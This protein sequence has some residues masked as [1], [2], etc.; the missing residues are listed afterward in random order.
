M[1]LRTTAPPWQDQ[2]LA[3][4]VAVAI[5]TGANN[6][7]GPGGSV[8]GVDSYHGGPAFHSG[9]W[10]GGDGGG[11]GGAGD[12][13]YGGIVNTYMTPGKLIDTVT[14]TGGRGA[15]NP[16]GGA[17]GA[18]GNASSYAKSYNASG[19]AYAYA[20]ATG[21]LSGSSYS[22]PSTTPVP[23]L[24]GGV[25]SGTYAV[26]SASTGHYAY[27]KVL[28]TGGMGG[29][30]I[31]YHTGGAGANSTLTDAVSASAQAGRIRLQQ[32]AVGGAGGT[33]LG[34]PA[35]G[36]GGTGTSSLTFT[37]AAAIPVIAGSAA[38]GGAGGLAAR[39]GRH[40]RRSMS[41]APTM[42]AGPRRRLVG[43]ADAAATRPASD[44]AAPAAAWPRTQ[45]RATTPGSSP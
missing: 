25:A 20:S 15:N 14:A 12:N 33:N 13:A 24:T 8:A 43:W 7:S 28:Q 4:E 11:V 2:S 37:D 23:A 10:T 5:H 31:G 1:L 30:A 45:R 39:A 32:T 44:P 21:G 29:A 6:P 36:A 17:L 34:G 42:S 38:V 41:P 16:G 18:G 40:R 27:A 19:D 9:T 35:G 3:K 26:A 22:N